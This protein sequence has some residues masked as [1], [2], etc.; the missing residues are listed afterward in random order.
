MVAFL[1]ALFSFLVFDYLWLGL[2]MKNFNLRQLAEI[3]RIEDGQF[4]VNYLAAGITYI[5]MALGIVVFVIPLVQEMPWWRVFLTGAL[6][7]LIVY[8]IFD[9]T[10]MAILKSY[11]FPFALADM[12]WGS[13]LFGVVS[14]IVSRVVS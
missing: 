2:V 1:V 6:L 12:A 7:G 14:I 10:N 11:P 9:M 3:G 8:G 5:L 13:F 4:Q